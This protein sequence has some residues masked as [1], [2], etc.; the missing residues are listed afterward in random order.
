MHLCKFAVS[1]IKKMKR[2][3]NVL[4]AVIGSGV[5]M[6]SCD[7]DDDTDTTA[8]VI[9]SATIDGKEEGIEANVG[10][11][12][13][14]EVK[15]SDNEA[16]GQLKLDVHDAFDGHSHDKSSGINW[17]NVA[18]ID[19]SGTEQTVSHDMEIPTNATAGPYHAEILVI[20]A[21]GNE[22]EFVERVIMIRNGSEPG[23]EI[24]SPDFTNEVHVSKG[25]TLSLE[26]MV[27]DETDLAEIL[28][29][30]E[31]E[32]EDAHKSV[33]HEALYEMDFDLEG[34]SDLTWDFQLDGNVNIAIPATAEEGHYVLTVRAED[35][36]GNINIFEAE[37]H[38]M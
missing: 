36:E 1:K 4:L 7:K 22:G 30:M 8:P 31:E 18:I 10:N 15:V 24:T 33:Q 2:I 3:F 28:I 26:G 13:T 11:A 29:I 21:E 16:L 37:L 9:N 32:E 27:T 38:I 17:A 5:M 23:I 19:L 12:M 20:D 6:I 34:T 25:S 14:F 35:S